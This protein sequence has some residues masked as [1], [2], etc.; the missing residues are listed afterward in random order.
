MKLVSRHQKGIIRRIAKEQEESFL[1][2]A[3]H[4]SIKALI[5][6][7]RD[8]GYEVSETEVLERIM[9]DIDN[10][11]KVRDDPANFI[12]L[13]DDANLSMVR[14]YLISDYYG[15][16]ESKPIHRVLNLK[17]GLNNQKN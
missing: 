1:R 11:N 8:E 2:I 9:M 14:H 12:N 10:W 4:K 17:E 13:L 6:K 15:V 7:L 16:N 5:N 3:Q